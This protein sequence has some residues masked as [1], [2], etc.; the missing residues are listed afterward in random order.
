[1]KRYIVAIV[2]T[3]VLA[4][5]LS[6][7]TTASAARPAAGPSVLSA[8]VTLDL[9]TTPPTASL[10]RGVGAVSAVATGV[11]GAFE[12]T[13]N[14]DVSNCAYVGGAGEASA[15]TPGPDDA[16]TI[17][18]APSAVSV[19]NV[20]VLEYDAILARDSYSSGF[21]LLVICP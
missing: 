9:S 16:I 15:N 20:Y 1:M 6:L 18:T 10:A 11:D 7:V 12:V 21:H 3:V 17:S 19:N 14:R 4:A 2:A 13:F 8:V 5:G